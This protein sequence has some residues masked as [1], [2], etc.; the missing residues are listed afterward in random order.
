[1]PRKSAYERRL[2]RVRVLQRRTRDKEYRLRKKGAAGTQIQSPRLNFGEVKGMTPEE[3]R[4]YEKTLQNF[5]RSSRKSAY[6]RRLDRVRV[7]QRRTRDKEYRLRKKGAAGTQIQSPRL[8]FGEVKGMTPEELR[9]YEKTLQNFTLDKMSVLENGD[10][11]PSKTLKQIKRNIEIHNQKVEKARKKLKGRV[12]ESDT[13][14]PI[15]AEIKP[16]SAHDA[17]RLMKKSEKWRASS[18]SRI[19]AGHRRSAV[20]MLQAVGL[21]SQA[22]L[23]TNMSSAAV[24]ELIEE[25]LLD[26]LA[27]WY[28]GD[29]E[30]T[31]QEISYNPDDFATFE[32]GLK[33]RIRALSE[34]H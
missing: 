25:G 6:E 5:T 23:V 29:T 32:S 21:D 24:E 11:I 4:A 33:D 27:L 13:Y 12:L 8:N 26:D 20:A 22:S 31:Q 18:P 2:D 19:M 9:A 16:K 15:S 28:M 17:E 30:R 34:E 14:A 3:L 10:V 1:M 7:L